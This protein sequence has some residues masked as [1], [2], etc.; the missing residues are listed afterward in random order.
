[1]DIL[2]KGGRLLDPANGKDGLYDLL[3]QDGKIKEV[4]EKIDPGK[5]RVV[6]ASG[7]FVM[8]G[9]IDLHVHLRDP[10]LTYKETVDT[11]AEAAAHGGFT[12]I[13]AMPNTKPVMDEGHRVAYVHNKAR[14]V[15]PI[16]VFQAGA[17]TK[18]MKGEELSDIEGMVKAGS[19]AVSEDGKSVMNASLYRKAMKIA[20]RLNIPVL[21][22]CEDI[23]LV[24]GGVVNADRTMQAVG[25]KGI[26]NAVEDVIVARDIL[27][28]KET[29]VK[30]HL[31]HCSTKDS[32]RMV[33]EAKE[34][35]VRVTAEVCPH[36]FTLT[37]SD[38]PGNDANY[39]M[40]PPLRTREDVEALKQG[41]H[42][43]VM[44]VI[45]TDHAPH[46]RE[47]K[48]RTMQSAPFGIVGLETAVALT[49]TELVRPGVIT[50][51]QM[52]AK[53][54]ANPAKVLGIDKGTLSEG[55]VADV[56]II[57][58]EVEYIIDKN[59]FRSKGK[60]TPFDGRKVFGEVEMTICGGE[61]VFTNGEYFANKQSKEDLV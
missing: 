21:A 14:M 20:K 9:L 41:L 2:I 24:D 45:S 4:K 44:D 23:N 55:A 12:T 38:I 11:G 18:G 34:D 49:I 51:M 5:K 31:C 40:N 16:N 59:R 3:I 7:C 46:S 48:F 36:H 32:V 26:S 10:G 42:D 1:M 33:K 13:V 57:D 58:P 25:W 47:E 53:M 56:T 43:D 39:K 28:A 35:G 17:I 30:L 15:S 29:G 19:P 6:D 8:P 22:H 37:S 61:P 54:S 52:A 50:P 60:N 27:L